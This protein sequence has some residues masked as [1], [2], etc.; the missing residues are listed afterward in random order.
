MPILHYTEGNWNYAKMQMKNARTE[1][2]QLLYHP[3]KKKKKRIVLAPRISDIDKKQL[4]EKQH[5]KQIQTG[6]PDYF[7]YFRHK[8]L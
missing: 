2:Y 6:R 1:N 3:Y 8:L 5:K 7:D 4:T